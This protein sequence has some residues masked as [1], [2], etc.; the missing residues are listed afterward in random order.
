MVSNEELMQKYGMSA[1]EIQQLENE[2]DAF[3]EGV[4]PKGKITRVGRPKSAEEETRPIT[5]RLAASK[6]EEVDKKAASLG[7]S[8][9]VIMREAVELWLKQA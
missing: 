3:D 1:E 7:V 4:W 5:F 8:R 2:A 6:A 9:G